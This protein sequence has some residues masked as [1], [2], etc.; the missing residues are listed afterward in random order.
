MTPFQ[1]F[2]L[3]AVCAAAPF[4]LHS[5]SATAKAVDDT[6]LEFSR[7]QYVEQISDEA[8]DRFEACGKIGEGQLYANEDECESKMEANFYELWPEDQCGGSKITGSRYKSCYEQAHDFTC[9][10]GL[11]SVDD[12]MTYI[13]NC[14]A[15]QVCTDV[16]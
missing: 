7:E 11:S 1:R 13:S 8:C 9:E 15:S 16:E 6:P 10:S 5:C 3:L 2:T 4:T 14:N 12:Y